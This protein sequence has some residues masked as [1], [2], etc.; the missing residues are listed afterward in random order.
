MTEPDNTPEFDPATDA[1]APV[2]ETGTPSDVSVEPAP[3]EV[4]PEA[5]ESPTAPETPDTP[6]APEQPSEQVEIPV[7]TATEVKDPANDTPEVNA[8]PVSAVPTPGAVSDEDQVNPA[9]EED[10]DPESHVGDEVE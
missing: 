5:P 3:V 8:S 2:E 10:D 7:I 4:S 6:V 1:D 9:H